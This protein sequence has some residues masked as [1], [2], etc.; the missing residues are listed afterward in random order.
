MV[1]GGN[2][3][4]PRPAKLAPKKKAD[5]KAKRDKKRKKGGGAT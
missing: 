2:K 1:R 4:P 5:L 3:R